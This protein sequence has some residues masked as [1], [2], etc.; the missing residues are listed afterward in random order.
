MQSVHRRAV[1]I[2][3]AFALAL[4]ASLIF[5]PNAT[6]QLEQKLDA[7]EDALG[8]IYD[9]QPATLEECIRAAEVGSVTLGRFEE[10][11]LTAI[12]GKRAALMQWLPNL[13]ANF[14]YQKSKR[15]EL[16]QTVFDT[17]NVLAPVTFLDANG[18]PL[19][20]TI[21]GEDAFFETTV[22]IEGSERSEDISIDQT[23][24]SYSA[25]SNITLF[26]GLDRIGEMRQANA[27]LNAA[28]ATLTYQRDVLRESVVN[29]YYDY[30]RADRRVEVALEA[31]RLAEQELERSE[32]YFDL[33]ISTRS[34]VL[35]AKVL[36]QQRKLDIVRERSTRR[37]AFLALA[38]SMNIP[39]AR[40]FEVVDDLPSVES[41]QV[42]DVEEL[43]DAARMQRLDLVAT[44]FNL[45]ASEAGVT[46]ARSGYWPSIQAFVQYSRSVSETPQ[47]LRLGGRENESI[48]YGVQGQWN[49]FDR[50]RTQQQT[51][52]AV[53][54]RRRA[55]YDL[56]Q[57]QL[58]IEL[59][60][61]NLWN[62]LNEAVESYQVSV[63]SVEQSREDM[64]L[65]EERFRV[66]A[67]TAL[68]VITAQVNLAQA[69][70]D[71]VDSQV[72]AIK[73]DRQL[74]RAVGATALALVDEE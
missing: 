65:A 62:N 3:R 32:T 45:D 61:V 38:H 63:V 10:D 26:N 19:P 35:Q 29:A 8:A 43:L 31:E 27:N 15:T 41:L 2:G 69:Q 57:R 36:V 64:R 23:F 68:D 55:E 44:Q 37:N 4:V 9:G 72:N 20:L 7:L 30:I 71:L 33:G 11:V 53:A 18:D 34:E 21:G 60:V 14:N 40:P 47:S 58:D 5:V 73:F 17:Q 54:A 6:A 16:D 12:T 42:P 22:P 49:I 39:G 48:S 24:E 13:S 28:E 50:W 70:R 25:S 66:G 51:R 1:L 56:R 46:R 59:E 52:N 67:G 74:Q